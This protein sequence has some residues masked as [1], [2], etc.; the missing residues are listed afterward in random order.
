M[1]WIKKVSNEELLRRMQRKKTLIHKIGKRLDISRAANEETHLGKVNTY[2]RDIGKHRVTYLISFCAW[3]A[4]EEEVRIVKLQK[5][6]KRYDV[7]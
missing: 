4:E 6:Y 5:S 2:K 3:I 1:L 7:V